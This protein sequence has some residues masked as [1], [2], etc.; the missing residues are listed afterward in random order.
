MIW[1]QLDPRADLEML[2]ALPGFL[3]EGDRRPAAVQFN[4]R[5]IYGGWDPQSGFTMNEETG[6]ISYPGDPPMRPIYACLLNNGELVLVYQYS[7]VAIL[8]SD[9]SFEVCRMD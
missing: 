8:Q 9:M 7:Y 5:Y 3:V 6:E 4:E 2:G 1:V